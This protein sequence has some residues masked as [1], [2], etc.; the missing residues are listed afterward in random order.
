MIGFYDSLP[1]LWR[2]S[3]AMGIT[4]G[5]GFA[6][7]MFTQAWLSFKFGSRIKTNEQKIENVEALRLKMKL[8]YDEKLEAEVKKI[9]DTAKADREADKEETKKL[10]QEIA[11]SW[12][13]QQ[14]VHNQEM[15]QVKKFATLETERANLAEG[16]IEEMRITIGNLNDTIIEIRKDLKTQGDDIL[17]LQQERE[18][19]RDEKHELAEANATLQKKV[20]ELEGK[21]LLS[22]AEKNGMREIAALVGLQRNMEK[23]EEAEQPPPL[24]AT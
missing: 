5:L 23:V 9:N 18:R 19:E 4:L 22:E 1:E 10:L 15:E 11:D 6:V 24:N 16:Q 17:A 14:T 2:Y 8:D 12:A 7:F 3:I 21:L 20:T 13:N